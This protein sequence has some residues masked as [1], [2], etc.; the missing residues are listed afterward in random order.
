MKTWHSNEEEIVS[1]SRI[2]TNHTKAIENS[3]ILAQNIIVTLST[4]KTVRSIN[5]TTEQVDRIIPVMA[6]YY[7]ACPLDWN[8][9]LL[10]GT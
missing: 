3:F 4:D 8:T 2:V 6:D 1:K 10:G 9:A 7:S 5:L